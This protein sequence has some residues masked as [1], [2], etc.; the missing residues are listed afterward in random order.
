[1]FNKKKEKK[2]YCNRVILTFEFFDHDI[3]GEYIKPDNDREIKRII[4]ATDAYRALSD[5][6]GD[7]RKEFRAEENREKSIE[8]LY[9]F[10][11]RKRTEYCEIM[12]DHGIDLEDLE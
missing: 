12:E 5:I 3:K 4:H 9:D 8:D 6:M 7:L 1:M 10:I 11:D 2:S